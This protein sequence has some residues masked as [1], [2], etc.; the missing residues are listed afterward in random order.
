MFRNYVVDFRSRFLSSPHL[1]SSHIRHRNFV[2]AKF[3][4]KVCKNC[5]MNIVFH[6][7]VYK[8]GRSPVVL[9]FCSTPE[10]RDRQH[11]GT[12]RRRDM[13]HTVHG[14]AVEKIRIKMS[15]F[16]SKFEEIVENRTVNTFRLF[17]KYVSVKS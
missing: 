3:H 10:C 9:N 17:N 2:L 11:S 8:A 13:L 16:V 5:S 6:S 7:L 14:V 1:Y 4:R 15:V 12:I